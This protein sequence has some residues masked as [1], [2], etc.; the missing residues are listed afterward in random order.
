MLKIKYIITEVYPFNNFDEIVKAISFDQFGSANIDQLKQSVKYTIN[1]GQSIRLR[2]LIFWIQSNFIRIHLGQLLVLFLKLLEKVQ[3]LE[4]NGIKHNYLDFNRIWLHLTQKSQYPSLIYQFLDY[5]IHFTGYDC[6][7]YEKTNDSGITEASQKIKEIIK[8]IITLCFDQI[9]FLRTNKN[10]RNSYYQELLQ[11]IVN[12][13]QPN[14]TTQQIIQIIQKNLSAF[15]YQENLQNNCFQCLNIDDKINDYIESPRYEIIPKIN[16]DLEQIIEFGNAFGQVVVESILLYYIPIFGKNLVSYSITDYLVK[17]QQQYNII[18]QREKKIR[19]SI[20]EQVIKTFE[21]FLL[22]KYEN[23]YKFQITKEEKDSINKDI[24]DSII[25]SAQ[26]QYFNNSY[27]LHINNE[28]IENLILVSISE[29][30]IQ[31]VQDQIDLFL[32]Y[33]ILVLIDELI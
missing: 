30:L 14:S 22:E 1:S 6:P 20:K 5:S 4:A 21:Y 27:W 24:I 15:N 19:D 28:E 10:T 3:F 2:D 25:E 33:K 12:L 16:K 18:S 29:I 31:Q 13:C 7:F 23:K 9:I 26:F 8:F 17:V 11:P 32:M